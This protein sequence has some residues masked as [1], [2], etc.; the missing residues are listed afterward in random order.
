MSDK[1]NVPSL[2]PIVSPPPS[3]SRNA[4]SLTRSLP[5]QVETA[6]DRDRSRR[7]SS[8]PGGEHDHQLDARRVLTRLLVPETFPRRTTYFF[9]GVG[10]SVRP[11]DSNGWRDQV[12]HSQRI[13]SF[14]NAYARRVQFVVP[15]ADVYR[16]ATRG[17]VSPRQS[18]G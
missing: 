18:Q 1:E 16:R 14:S 3:S 10:A 2:Y 7:A 6:G 12:V 11:R 8:L 9:P 17:V 15:S 4:S 13:S 5:G